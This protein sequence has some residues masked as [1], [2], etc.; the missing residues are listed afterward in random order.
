MTTSTLITKNNE[1]AILV[2]AKELE[3]VTC[4]QY[5]IIFQGDITQDSSVLDSMLALLDSSSEV[6]V[7]HP[8]FVEKLGFMVQT[9]NIGTQ[10]IN[11]TILETYKMVI[12]AFLMTDQADRVKFFEEIFLMANVSPDIVL[13]IPFFILNSAD[14]DF[15]KR[16]LWWK[17]YTIEET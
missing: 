14:V 5:P 17:S 7:I 4:I 2:S 15:S 1:E 6:N 8:T 11:S 13:G 16:E 12:A 3:Q 9:T 10:K